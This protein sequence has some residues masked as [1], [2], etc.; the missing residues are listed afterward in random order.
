MLSN[1][2]NRQR[3][4]CKLVENLKFDSHFEASRLRDYSS[5]SAVNCSA[6]APDSSSTLTPGV[7]EAN[8][9]QQ[10][11]GD[12]NAH[13]LLLAQKLNINKEAI[14]AQINEDAV[15]EEEFVSGNLQP[16][17]Q[18]VSSIEQN[19]SSSPSS[20]Q[21]Q[22]QPHQKIPSTGESSVQ[23]TPVNLSRTSSVSTINPMKNS[24]SSMTTA[25]P[26]ALVSPLVV[27]TS[28]DNTTQLEEKE[29]LILRTD[30]ELIT[31]TKVIKG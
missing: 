19:Q 25:S 29:K 8:N 21:Q 28:Y 2:E 15:G 4:R 16:Q 6:T 30:C 12:S 5:Y 1:H 14:N 31:V 11:G 26:T 13:K 7:A 17:Q 18:S 24:S 27:E 20:Q 22:Q 9:Q 23:T 3:M 10:I